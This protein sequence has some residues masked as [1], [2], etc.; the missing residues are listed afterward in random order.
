MLLPLLTT[1][2]LFSA[3]PA[4][5]WDPATTWT[6][7]VGVLSWKDKDLPDFSTYHRKDKELDQTLGERGV[8]EAQRV[9]LIDRQ[10]S[11]S[12]VLAAIARQ[13]TTAPPGATF[14]FYFT[15]H[16][17]RDPA[18]ELVLTTTDAVAEHLDRTG[19]HAA[20]LVPLF[21]LRGPKDRVLLLSDACTSGD[22]AAIALSL[23]MLGVPTASLTSAAAQSESTGNWTY[24]Q[25]LIDALR[26]APLLDADGDGTITLAEVA[27]EAKEA[28]KFREGQP[29]GFTPAGLPL[30]FVLARTAPWPD[31][32]AALDKDGDKWH[33]GDWVLARNPA[34]VRAVGRVLGAERKPA[35]R[36]KRGPPVVRL[37]LAFF[38][39]ADESLGWARED[40]V[41]PILFEDWPVGT[42]LKVEDDDEEYEAE[43]LAV[44]DDLHFVHYEGF[45]A[46]EDEWVT[47]DQ[48]I[49][50][51]APD[52]DDPRNVIVNGEAAWVKGEV[53]GKVCVRYP[54]T[55][56]TEDECVAPERV[57]PAHHAGKRR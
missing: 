18:G 21:A 31:E 22:L 43:V 56:W 42:H 9:L 33:R 13:V 38:G 41:Q 40:R 15:G 53:D 44:A 7:T 17:A 11:A 47:P 57:K 39:F 23:S 48:I 34:G 37:R 51:W 54:G 55:D 3:P 4:P 35:A 24:S 14:I 16:G 10:A 26:G 2:A 27:G 8:P 12:A 50:P 45:G 30:G 1:V 25:T 46:D 6:V 49:G 20:D 36:G 19:L 52:P 29:S 32:L 5:A 28:L